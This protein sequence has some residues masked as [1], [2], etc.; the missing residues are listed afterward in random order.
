MYRDILSRIAEPPVWFDEHAVPRFEPFTPRACADIYAEEVV[1]M[2]IECQACKREFLVCMSHGM[3]ERAEG[4]ASLAQ[5]IKDRHIHYGDPPNVECCA[6][7]P[8][9]NSVPR[10]VVEFW[11]SPD[12]EWE[13]EPE[14]EVDVLPEWASD[15]SG[16]P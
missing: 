2:A 9:M 10:R 6:P 13:R 12:F 11:R 4:R 15:E 5:Q 14:L 3:T 1:L 16:E 8:T 7:G